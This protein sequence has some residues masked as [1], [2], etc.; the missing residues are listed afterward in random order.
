MELRL[1]NKGKISVLYLDKINVIL[2]KNQSGKT[3]KLKQLESIFN[4]NGNYA[5]L[6]GVEITNGLFNVIHIHE[7]RDLESEINIKSKSAFHMNV[8]KPFVTEEYES[9]RNYTEV[10]AESIK[11]LFEKTNQSNYNYNLSSNNIRL[12]SK[13]VEKLETIIFEIISNIR[14]SKGSLEEFYLYQSL[15]QIMDG[16]NNVL[17]I[18][19]I[20][21][22]LDQHTLTSYIE[23][24]SRIDNLT[25]F[26]TTKN[27]YTLDDL[28]I[29]KYINEEFQTIDLSTIAKEEMYRK[30]QK[31]ENSKLSLDN[32]ILQN[33]NFYSENDYNNFLNSNLIEILKKIKL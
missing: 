16:M 27:K 6:N 10:F 20:D 11:E 5:L 30:Y 22:Y 7:N 4:G 15:L 9:I 31:M 8:I 33:E 19:D 28:K 17:L 1:E 32:Y 29:T 23:H 21:R 18:D 13:K 25:I 14:H 26:I 2:G 12:D 24:L 3:H